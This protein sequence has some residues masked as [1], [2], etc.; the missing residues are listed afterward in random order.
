M[1][2]G[3]LSDAEIRIINELQAQMLQRFKSVGSEAIVEYQGQKFIVLPNVFWPFDDSLPLVQNFKIN[4]EDKVLDVGTGSGVLA[5]FAGLKGART[6]VALDVNPAAV[7]NARRNARLHHL[8]DTIDVRQSDMLEAL[9]EGERFDVIIA[10]L[11]FRDKSAGDIVQRSMWDGELAA[12]K[13]FFETVKNY[14]KPGGRLYLSQS[15]FGAVDE[16][17]ALAANKGFVAQLIGKKE[18]PAG[19][20]RVFYA[21]K[22]YQEF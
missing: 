6:V 14:L 12:N 1:Y 9:R 17:L 15:N 2:K 8:S 11:P 4:A 10:N 16:V 22:L 18:M 3:N 7:E 21:F 20:P 19:D 13:K 5:V